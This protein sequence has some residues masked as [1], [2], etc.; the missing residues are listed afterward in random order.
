M[1]EMIKLFFVIIIFSAVSGGLLAALQA[2]TKERIVYQELK[3][4]R[5][6]ALQMIMEGASNNPLNDRFELADD[7]GKTTF[8]IGVFEGKPNVVAFE[9]FGKGFEDDIGVIVAVD[10]KTD[11]IFGIGITTSR[12]TPG[13][14][15][16]VR[17]DPAFGEQF[18][19]QSIKDPFK[20]RS[21]GGQIDAI[22]GASFSSRGVCEA[23][24]HSVEIFKRLRPEIMKKVDAFKA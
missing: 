7:K 21:E 9:T 2:T 1:R 4:V 22:S 13:V 15:S 20:I 6:P 11:K 8:F 24:N 14:G 19:G 18:K 16:K 23:L 17:D 5:G 10:L 12:E 3:F